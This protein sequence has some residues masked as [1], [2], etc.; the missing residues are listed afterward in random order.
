MSGWALGAIAL[1]LGLAGC[2][3]S[4][5]DS[6]ST[7]PQVDPV[8]LHPSCM[9]PCTIKYEVRLTSTVGNATYR[10][11]SE[12]T[13]LVLDAIRAKLATRSDIDVDEGRDLTTSSKALR[14]A[15][16][17]TSLVYS[18]GDL[19]ASI[20]LLVYRNS[21]GALLGSITKRVT[22]PGVYAVDENKENLVISTAASLATQQFIDNIAAYY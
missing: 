5:E 4:A 19:T 18:S 11:D 22:M 15:A 2:S 21:S 20:Q 7:A 1:I 14:I 13:P 8:G 9:D 12:I 6:T 10:P 3:A 16:S 17:V